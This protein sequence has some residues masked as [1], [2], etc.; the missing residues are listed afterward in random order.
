MLSE[1]KRDLYFSSLLL[2]EK[3]KVRDEMSYKGIVGKRVTFGK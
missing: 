1:E 3:R 2:L